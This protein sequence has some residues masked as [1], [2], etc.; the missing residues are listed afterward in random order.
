MI[1][2]IDNLLAIVHSSTT[3]RLRK[4][5]F[6]YVLVDLLIIPRKRWRSCLSEDP[7]G[8][9]ICRPFIFGMWIHNGV[10]FVLNII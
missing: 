3:L 10:P 2:I 7:L 1:C 4:Y 6:T 9:L 5:Y 8:D